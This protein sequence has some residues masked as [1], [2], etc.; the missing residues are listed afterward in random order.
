MRC[1]LER[2]KAQRK[3]VAVMTQKKFN[4]NTYRIDPYKNPKF[5]TA[6]SVAPASTEGEPAKA[7]SKKNPATSVKTTAGKTVKKAAKQA[8]PRS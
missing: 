5:R 2:S 6:V 1:L 4:V 3:W 8:A 7:G